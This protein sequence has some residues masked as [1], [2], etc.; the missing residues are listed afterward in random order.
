MTVAEHLGWNLRKARRRTGMSQEHL[1]RRTGLHHTEIS[2]LERG[3]RVARLDTFMK[4]AQCTEADP[5]ELVEGIT[6]HE[7]PGWDAPGWFTVVGLSE[8]ADLRPPRRGE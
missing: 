6:W 1:S 4:M 8:P 3:I 2:M 7:P 5:T